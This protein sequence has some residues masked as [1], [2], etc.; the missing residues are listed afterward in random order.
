MFNKNYQSYLKT[1]K[2]KVDEFHPISV[3]EIHPKLFEFQKDVVKMLLDIGRGAAFLDTGLGKT[4]VQCEWARHIK[5]KVLIVAPLAVAQQT[6]KEA[7]K[8]LG[9]HIDYSKDGTVKSDITITNYERVENFDCELFDGVVLD[10]SSILKGQTSKTKAMICERFKDTKYRLACT[11]T[12]AP[13]DYTELGNHAEFLGIM[14]TQEMLMRWFLHDSANTGDWR[15]KGHAVKPFWEWVS[16]WAACVSKPS[17]LGY[18]N[19]GYDLPPLNMTTHTVK[20]DTKTAYDDGLLFEMPDINAAT[21]HKKKRESVVD[22]VG[23]VAEMVNESKKPWIVWC[24]SNQES[25]MLKKAI[26]DAVEVKG[27]DNPDTKEERLMG[28]SDGKYRV[29]IS[30]SKI[31]GFGM[32]WQHCRDMVFASISYSYEKFYQAVRRSWRFGQDQ[33]VNVHVV[34]ADAELPVWR[35]VEAKSTDH[36]SMKDHMK[37]AVFSKGASSDVKVDY[38]P[39]YVATLPDW[40]TTTHID[41]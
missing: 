39:D 13:N 34:I 15:L 28:F 5:G 35:T 8:H 21:L 30:K 7:K 33:Q 16:S 32:N 10:E 11:A 19:E 25:E 1:K 18:D 31:C 40:I 17:D 26:P 41:Q 29:L 12:P 24:E 38:L 6:I 37:Y 22:R 2:N 4:I 36:E 20:V 3:K 23:I 27:S 9:L 14:S